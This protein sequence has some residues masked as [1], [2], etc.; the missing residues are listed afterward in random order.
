MPPGMWTDIVPSHK[1]SRLPTAAAA[2]L[3]LPE[4]SV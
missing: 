3:L 1:P 2:Q 4:A